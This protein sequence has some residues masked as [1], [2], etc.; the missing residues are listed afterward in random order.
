MPNA[1]LDH[2]APPGILA[3]DVEAATRRFKKA[4]TERALGAELQHYLAQEASSAL[5]DAPATHG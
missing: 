3:A 1:V 2:I 5:P 4:L